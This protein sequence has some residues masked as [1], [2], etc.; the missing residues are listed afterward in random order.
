MPIYHKTN[1]QVTVLNNNYDLYVKGANEHFL[2]KTQ[3]ETINFIKI[4]HYP[5]PEYPMIKV[6]IN[7]KQEKVTVLKNDY[8]LYKK[9]NEYFIKDEKNQYTKIEHYPETKNPMIKVKII[10]KPLKKPSI[11]TIRRL[12][13]DLKP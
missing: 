9:E 13:A 4:E 11:S 6:K 5:E 1:K 10:E 7:K 2:K 8:G 3:G 12:M